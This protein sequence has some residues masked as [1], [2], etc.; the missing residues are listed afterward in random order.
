M[1]GS[2]EDRLAQVPWYEL[3]HAYGKA[4]RV[5]QWL[6]ELRSTDGKVQAEAL[7][8]LD[9]TICHQGTRYSASPY[10]VP[11]LIELLEGSALK[12]PD[13]ILRLLVCLAVGYA[14]D[15]V[16]TGFDLEACLTMMERSWGFGDYLEFNRRTYHA[17]RKGVPVF[18][19]LLDDRDLNVRIAAAYAL[20]WF[21]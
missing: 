9:G 13:G 7:N 5:P 17:V 18:I 14:A 1:S 8:A 12:N 15:F 19:R 6:S 21:K 16:G 2:F 11:F 4:E 20:A 10:A 3:E